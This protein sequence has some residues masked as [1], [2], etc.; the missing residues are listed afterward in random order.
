MSLYRQ[1]GRVATRT[2]ALGAAAL[3]LIGLLGGFV[4]GRVT[5][6]EPTLADEVGALRTALRPADQGL[7]LTATEY[8]QAVHDG[9]V[10]APTEYGAARSDVQRV[11]EVLAATRTDLR[12]LSPAR[13]A[14]F[15]AA[16]GEVDAGVRQRVDPSEL[17]RRSDAARRALDAVFAR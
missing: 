10:T 5:A 2:V 1:T 7:E 11:R 13:A 3:L 9:E 16:V 17:Q 14:A 12:A 6:A 15:E 4:L 8:A